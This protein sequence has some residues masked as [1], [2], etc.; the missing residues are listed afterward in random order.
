MKL[1]SLPT[2]LA[3]LLLALGGTAA[4]AASP[5]SAPKTAASEP[6]SSPAR[7]VKVDLNSA[8][9][10]ELMQLP[11]INAARAREIIKNRHYV[12]PEDLLDRQVLTNKDLKALQDKFTLGPAPK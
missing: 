11:G 2:A 3:T 4:G 8:S 7:L 12:T 9:E 10:K 1:P 6:A 5:A